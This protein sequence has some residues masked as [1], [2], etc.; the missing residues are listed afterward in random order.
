MDLGSILDVTGY[1]LL[2]IGLP[3]LLLVVLGILIDRWERKRRS[4]V[5]TQEFEAL[6]PPHHEHAE[7]RH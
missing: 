4:A 2:R 7:T 5:D 1:F 6:A 3:V